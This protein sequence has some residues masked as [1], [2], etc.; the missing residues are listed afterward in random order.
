MK[1]YSDIT[2]KRGTFSGMNTMFEQWRATFLFQEEGEEWRRT[3]TIKLLGEDHNPLI[4]WTAKNAWPKKIQSTDLKAD[5]N[6][7]AIETMEICH[8]GLTVEHTA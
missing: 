4:V 7:V 8:E 1:K 2:C 3:V 5:G 6:E